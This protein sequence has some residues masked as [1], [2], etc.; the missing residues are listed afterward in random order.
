M[1]VGF[2]F[3]KLVLVV[4]RSGYAK[5]LHELC[6]CGTRFIDCPLIYV[7][8][9]V[10]TLSPFTCTYTS[11]YWVVRNF[12]VCD[13]AED[14]IREMSGPGTQE[15]WL[16]WRSKTP[17]QRQRCAVMKELS[18]LVENTV[19]MNTVENHICCQS[20]LMLNLRTCAFYIDFILCINGMGLWRG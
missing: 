16:Y 14:Q 11:T 18:K 9:L 15:Q 12:N 20:D 7:H 5:R 19:W 17:E 6:R 1:Y 8:V 3:S 4:S 2:L 13:A 10:C